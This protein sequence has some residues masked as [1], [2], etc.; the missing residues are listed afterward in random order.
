MN[1]SY[2]C[3]PC[4]IRQS[5]DAVRFATSDEEIHESV[6]RKVLIAISRMNLKK[7]PPVMGQKIHRI[8]RTLSG[9]SD[10]Y[11]NVKREFNQYALS[12]YPSLKERIE[13]SPAR[14]DTAVRLA[15]SGNIIDFGVNADIDQT[16]I[17]KT[18]ESSL[19]GPLIGDME[20]FQ[21]IIGSS[22]NILYLGDNAGEIVFDRLLIEQLPIDRVIFAVRGSPVINDATHIDALETGMTKI[23]RV[24]DNGSDAPGTVIEECSDTFNHLFQDADLV[25][26]KGQGNYETLADSSKKIFFLLKAKCPVIAQHLD[27]C[28]GDSVI[29]LNDHKIS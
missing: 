11:R 22:E 20:C 3:I 2:D 10:P 8:I 25:I 6:L 26:A 21:E 19:S 13:K 1:T 4:F 17:H 27:C 29:R 14:F 28:V 16:V 18:I 23:V 9:S 24:V 5:L 15:I 12:L 7:S